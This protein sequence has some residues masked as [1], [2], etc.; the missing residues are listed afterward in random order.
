MALAP[1]GILC[2]DEVPEFKRHVLEV[3]RQ[4]LEDGVVTI[5]SVLVGI[6]LISHPTLLKA[7]F[8]RA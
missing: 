6:M 3:L 7:V 8:A 5:A 4:P 2:L 1:H